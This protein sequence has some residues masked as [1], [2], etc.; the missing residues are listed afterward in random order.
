LFDWFIEVFFA[1]AETGLDLD[2]AFTEKTLLVVCLSCVYAD[3]NRSRIAFVM[4]VPN[5]G[6]IQIVNLQTRIGIRAQRTRVRTP[7]V[8]ARCQ[9]KFLTCEISDFTSCTHAQSNILHTNYVD[10]TDY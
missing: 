3:S 4:L 10:K 2:S 9:A 6:R 5:P 1:A 8:H 7:P